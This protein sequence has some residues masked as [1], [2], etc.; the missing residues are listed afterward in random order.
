M[1][2]H[3]KESQSSSEYPIVIPFQENFGTVT[4]TSDRYF[5]MRGEP[6]YPWLFRPSH[7]LAVA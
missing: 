7:K 1:N 4:F 2:I 6:I 5:L 3:R